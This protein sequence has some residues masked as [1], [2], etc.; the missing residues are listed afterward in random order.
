MR[1]LSRWIRAIAL[2]CVGAISVLAV[3]DNR[4]AVALHFLG[5]ATPALS[6]Y[7]WLVGAFVLGIASGWLGAGVHVLR[8]RAGSRQL[9]RELDRS[10][11]ELTRIK[12][13]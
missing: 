9:R 6:V 11:S 10:Q 4:D 8:V 2:L 7:W 5:W 3:I 12:S 13:T 1:T